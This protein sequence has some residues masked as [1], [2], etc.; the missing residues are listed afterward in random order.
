MADATLF[1]AQRNPI[2]TP[3]RPN[4]STSPKV[5][6][7]WKTGIFTARDGTEQRWSERITPRLVYATIRNLQRFVSS[8]PAGAVLSVRAFRVAEPLPELY[9]LEPD[10]V[11]MERAGP[12]GVTP[13][14]VAAQLGHADTVRVLLRCGADGSAGRAS[15]QAL[16]RSARPPAG[17]HQYRSPRR[18]HAIR[19]PLSGPWWSQR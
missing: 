7:A 9:E 2:A 6:Y 8:A 14:F 5:K 15:G 13:L 18:R 16:R 3:F 11:H 1:D 10:D 19:H 4:W 12:E 17:R